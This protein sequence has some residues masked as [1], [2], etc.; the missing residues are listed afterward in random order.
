MSRYI[1]VERKWMKC[2]I[3][4]YDIEHCQC[5]FG[6]SAHPD[7]SK[8]R[9]VVLDHLY[10]FSKEQVEHILALER[11]WQTSYDDDERSRIRDD[12]FKEYKIGNV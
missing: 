8:R 1:D 6:G 3:C 2:P 7:R 4:N 5:R 12:L 10:L 11:Y 9:D